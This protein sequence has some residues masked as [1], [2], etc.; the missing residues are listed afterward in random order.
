MDIVLVPGFWLDAHSWDAVT[1][2]LTGAG[3]RVHPITLPGMD[4]VDTPRAGI[5]LQT[6]IDAVTGVVDALDGPVVLV[7]HSGG[8]AVAYGVS[9]AR[10]ERISR[11]VYVDSGPLGPG[12]SI[13]PE[14]APEGG[15]LELLP[16]E[17][18]EPS[19]L[20]DLDEE[21]R[22]D[23]RARAVPV[24]HGVAADPI[25]LHDERRLAVPSTVI[26][27]TLSAAQLTEWLAAGAPFLAELARLSD[28]EF[29][30]LPTG[31]WPQFTKPAELAA[32][33][34]AAVDR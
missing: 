7:G 31:H 10:P 28:V 9:D 27:C 15:D 26:T 12:Q 1:P 13:N 17:E 21:M 33:I 16:W 25:Q 34:L 3:H 24:P 19:E 29:V 6:N 30:E 20:T 2:A 11:V 4:S 22:A 32:A 14:L 23:F 18:F 5:G 8:G